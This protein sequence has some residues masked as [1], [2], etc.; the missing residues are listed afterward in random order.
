MAA[1]A[2][3]ETYRQLPLQSP[4]ADAARAV[5]DLQVAVVVAARVVAVV[6]GLVVETVAVA[7]VAAVDAA[8]A[9]VLTPRRRS[10]HP[11]RATNKR[12]PCGTEI[13]SN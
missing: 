7:V 5:G 11:L 9:L 10:G 12:F 13:R 2:A 4:N 1:V 8:V 3:Y 6:L